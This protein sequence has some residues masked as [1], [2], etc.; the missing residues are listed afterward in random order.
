M[1]KKDIVEEIHRYAR[2]N[3]ERRKYSMRGIADTLQ[4]DLI[5]MQPFKNANRGYAYILIVIDIFSK[6]AYTQPLKDKTA[7][8]TSQAMEKILIQV[9]ERVRHIHS[10]DGKEFFNSAM[11]R[12]LAQYG[13]IN[14][15]STY[16]YKK[17]SIVERLIRT[18]K[19]KLYMQ[20]SLQGS[21]KWYDILEKIIDVY[22][23]T[24]HRTIKMSPNNV[25]HE[26]EQRLLNTVYNYKRV[27]SKRKLPKFKVGDHVRISDVRLTFDKSYTPNWSTAIFIIRKVQL[28]TD[29]ITYLLKTF[30]NQE[31]N[32][33]MYAEELQ[34]VKNPHEY[35]VEKVLRKRNNQVY[36]KWLGFDSSYNSWIAEE[37]LLD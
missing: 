13:N 9:G 11:T 10:D 34:L 6:K 27:Y 19:R 23:T 18:I 30:D 33:S 31:I 16:S 12:L 5:D 7:R 32:G 24:R 2:K 8:S 36:V 22:N 1:P 29:P 26:N 28:N 37:D 20:F 4:A 21:N 3:F 25:T 15:Y 35:L 17:A 14:H